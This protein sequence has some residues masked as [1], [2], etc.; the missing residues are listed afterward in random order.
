MLDNL[1]TKISQI[2]GQFSQLVTQIKYSASELH[3]DVTP[4]INSTS[5]ISIMGSLVQT[6]SIPEDMIPSF[7]FSEGLMNAFGKLTQADNK[8]GSEGLTIQIQGFASVIATVA[9]R[10][11]PH[12]STTISSDLAAVE[13]TSNPQ[14]A[15]QALNTL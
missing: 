9:S 11:Y 3:E 6:L 4:P 13:N 8:T 1:A 5:I 14:D 7:N 15:W 10:E 2:G 12:N